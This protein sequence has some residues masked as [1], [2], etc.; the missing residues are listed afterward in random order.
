MTPTQQNV[1]DA[2]V[3]SLVNALK[4]SS[5]GQEIFNSVRKVEPRGFHFGNLSEC[6]LLECEK[7]ESLPEFSASLPQAA[8]L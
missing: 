8:S 4:G 5:L 7:A 1:E 3:Q 2:S 6:V